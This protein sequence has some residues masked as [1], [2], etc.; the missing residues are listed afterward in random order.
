MGQGGKEQF[1]TGMAAFRRHGYRSIATERSGKS[2]EPRR[3]LAFLP[4]GSRQLLATRIVAMLF[5]L[6]PLAIPL[7]PASAS[8]LS[9]GLGDVPLHSGS[10]PVTPQDPS[11]LVLA[12]IGAGT[13][14]IYVA[15][16]WRPGRS[17]AA[18]AA[19][20]LSEQSESGA[21]LA[22]EETRSRG[23]A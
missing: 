18:R 19:G 6:N 20:R 16:K 1:E 11:T 8:G 17:D 3:T 21:S 4:L 7:L 15:A 22:V 23:A 12:L 5:T 14:A 10:T 13:I 2:A 9:E